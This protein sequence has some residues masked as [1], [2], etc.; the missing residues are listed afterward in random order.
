MNDFM[1]GVDLLPKL[2]LLTSNSDYI[3]WRLIIQNYL[4]AR[5][6]WKYVNG[7]A[8]SDVQATCE[9]AEQYAA[10]HQTWAMF[11]SQAKVRGIVESVVNCKTSKEMFQVLDRKYGGIK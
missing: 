1:T 6:L 11:D 10:M 3:Y 9:D 7:Q 2:A 5:G 8:L 4:S